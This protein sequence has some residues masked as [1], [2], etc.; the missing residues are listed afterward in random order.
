MKFGTSGLRGLATDLLSPQTAAYTKAFARY[1]LEIGALRPGGRIFIGRDLRASSPAISALSANVLSGMGLNVVDCGALPTP[2]LAGYAW[3][4][5]AA[6]LMVTGSHIP[7]ER[8]GIKFFLPDAEIGKSDEAAITAMVEAPRVTDELP[9]RNYG[10]IAHEEAK[11]HRWYLDRSRGLATK[12]ALSG[13]KIGVYQHSSV[14]RDF[15]IELL[16]SLGASVMPLARTPYFIAVDTEA[17][18]AETIEMFSSWAGEYGLDAIVSADGDADR[19]LIADE[20]GV[21]LRGDIIG[22]V[23]AWWVGADIV[24][25]PITSNSGIHS[26]LGFEVVRTRVGSPF[27]ISAMRETAMDG[28]KV[29][30]FEA[31]GGFMLGSSFQRNGTGG[32]ALPTRDAILPILAVLQSARQSGV[33]LSVLAKS[34]PLPVCASDRLEHFPAEQ[35]QALMEHLSSGNTALRDFLSPLGEVVTLDRTDGL[36]V[37]LS[38][39]EIVHLRPSGN[40]PELRCYAE[41]STPA[42]AQS[43]V[44]RALDRVRSWNG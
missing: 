26:G 31:N 3:S 20:N 27:V 40:A 25:T 37:T 36:R 34:W 10:F 43:L 8:N 16:E 38:S 32:S 11:A 15:L 12:N 29:V 14:A 7:A 39:G 18:P 1:L 22:L 19:P 21:Q 30:G 41:A 44:A 5:G 9:T 35:S 6:A 4:H 28:R 2:A 42:E 23:T 13:V 33:A 24:V 17:I